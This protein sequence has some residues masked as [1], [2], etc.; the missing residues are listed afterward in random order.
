MPKWARGSIHSPRLATD[1]RFDHLVAKAA[2]Q[3][4]GVV[5]IDEAPYFSLR[6]FVPPI[7]DQAQTGACTG[8]AS[9]NFRST[10]QAAQGGQQIALSPTWLYREER[11]LEGTLGRDV[12]AMPVDAMRVM[13]T[14]GFALWADYVPNFG[15]LQTVAASADVMT[16][17]AS[18]K[19]GAY[20]RVA[21]S[22]AAVKAALAS[23]QPVLTGIEV[24][25]NMESTEVSQTGILPMPDK[26]TGGHAICIVGWID[27]PNAPGGGHFEFA[28]SWSSL[29]G[30]SG[31]GYLP[32]AMLADATWVPD[33]WT[34][35]AAPVPMT[36][37][38][39]RYGE[40]WNR[41]EP[42]SPGVGG[43]TPLL[44]IVAALLNHAL[45]LEGKDAIPASDVWTKA[46]GDALYRWQEVHCSSAALLGGSVTLGALDRYS[47][48]LL[49]DQAF[50]TDQEGTI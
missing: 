19:I 12:G 8:C 6:R 45:G 28:N 50:P 44:P 1:P 47:L 7:L 11:A 37:A 2:L 26:P 33:L 17:A 43:P 35:S 41:L 27:N 24:P 18:F 16:R 9:R 40:L 49:V 22:V 34:A 23:G 20:G 10:L 25:A 3:A 14:D 38:L 48:R 15:T 29:W 5:P 39:A 21:N 42:P 13:A 30:D 36:V 32:Y 4:P 46:L 31:F